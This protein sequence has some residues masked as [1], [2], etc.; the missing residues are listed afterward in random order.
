MRACTHRCN[1]ANARARTYPC[2]CCDGDGV[3]KQNLI[4]TLF[5]VR[6]CVIPIHIYTGEEESE[7]KKKKKKKKKV[8]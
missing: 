8:D 1:H 2:T 3:L 6:M 7:K 5:L 4:S